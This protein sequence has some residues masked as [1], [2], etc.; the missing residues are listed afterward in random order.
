MS[1]ALLKG[2]HDDVTLVDTDKITIGELKKVTQISHNGALFGII[3]S[4][5]GLQYAENLY[6]LAFGTTGDNDYDID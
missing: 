6:Y 3:D 1:E 5:E 2:I 4:L